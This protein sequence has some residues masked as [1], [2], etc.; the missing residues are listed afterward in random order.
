M[1]EAAIEQVH[2][3]H[4]TKSKYLV[5]GLGQTGYS[6]VRY[7]CRSG[8][9]V[10]VC[11]SRK[12]PP[13]LEFCAA[14]FPNVEIVTGKIPLQRIDEFDEVITSPGIGLKTDIKLISDI[15]LFVRET[16]SEIV[17]ITG[18]NGKSTV[19]MLVYEMLIAADVSTKIAGNIGIPALD[20]LQLP[21]PDTVVLEL[22]SFQLENTYSLKADCAA[23]LNIS[24]DHMDRYNSLEEYKDAKARILSAAK[25]QVVG[26]DDPILST[27]PLDRSNIGFTLSVPVNDTDFGVVS[28]D[29]KSFLVQGKTRLCAAED[30]VLV[31]QHNIA[32]VLAAMALVH[33][34]GIELTQPVIEAACHY[35]GLPHRCENL[36][37]YHGV[38]WINDSKG[39]NVGATQAALEGLDGPII[40]IAGG[41]AKG[42]DFSQLMDIVAEKVSSLI[43][44]GEDAELIERYLHEVVTVIHVAS[45]EAVVRQ[46]GELAQPGDTVLFSP[47]CSSFDMFENY[48][49]RGDYFKQL[50]HE[51]YGDDRA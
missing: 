7:L 10:V 12:R 33:G 14:Q 39:T 8:H 43:V 2:T 34:L 31:G 29:G 46:A 5:I 47:A 40:L 42:A 22:S 4:Q 6:I 51:M 41:L 35:R 45:L 17:A 27:M 13:M 11:D 36:G 50:V 20:L 44:F 28:H 38:N 21:S 32:N 49:K 19:T 9:D 3:M 15:E 30:I 18:S 26:R 24:P 37:S 16:P 23:L 1:V 25:V 48:E